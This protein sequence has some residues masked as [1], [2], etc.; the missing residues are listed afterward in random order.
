MFIIGQR[1]D[2]RESI[3]Q[4]REFANELDPDFV[5]FGILTPFPGTEIYEEANRNGWILDKNWAH[6]DMIH[7]IMPTETL[8]INEVQEELYGC[9]RDFYGSWNRRF[10]GLFGSNQ[11]KRKV[12][13]HMAQS[14]VLEKI[15]SMF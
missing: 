5:M 2:T 15:K 14:G 11:L 12:F 8:T 10:R 9:Y 6:Y 13:W 3:K 7:A 1:K 4:L